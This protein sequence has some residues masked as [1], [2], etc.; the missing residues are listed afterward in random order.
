MCLISCFSNKKKILA[1]FYKDSNDKLLIQLTHYI[2]DL[3][4]SKYYIIG[5]NANNENNDDDDKFIL[6]EN[7][8]KNKLYV[9]CDIVK[10]K[11]NY[12]LIVYKISYS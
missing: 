10:N 11:F 12:R 2:N 7:E 1:E 9:F 6:F 3:F 8:L 5:N 4:Q